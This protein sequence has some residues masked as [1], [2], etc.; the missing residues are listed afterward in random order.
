MTPTETGTYTAKLTDGPLEGT[1]VRTAF[2]EGG[3]PLARLEIPQGRETRPTSMS[4]A[5]PGL[6]STVNPAKEIAR[7]RSATGSCAQ[8][9]SNSSAGGHPAGQRGFAPR[10]PP[11]VSQ[12]AVRR[13]RRSTQ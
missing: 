3:N 1:T 11:S 8:P 4:S 2:T 13:G 9:S 7:A 12:A 5:G 6:S 10:R